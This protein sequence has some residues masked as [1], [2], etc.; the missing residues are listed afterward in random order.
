MPPKPVTREQLEPLAESMAQFTTAANK[1]AR[2]QSQGPSRGSCE[3]YITEAG[4]AS[5]SWRLPAY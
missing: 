1:E 5:R 2:Y 3:L 4:S